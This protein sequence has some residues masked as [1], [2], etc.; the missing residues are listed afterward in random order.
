MTVKELRTAINRISADY[1][2]A[3]VLIPLVDLAGR[4]ISSPACEVAASD[5]KT[6]FFIKPQHVQVFE[7][8]TVSSGAELPDGG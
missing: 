6:K 5:N 7:D 8:V 2:D 1:D 3:I 4:Y